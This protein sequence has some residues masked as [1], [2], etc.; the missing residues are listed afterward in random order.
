MTSL[1]SAIAEFHR[2]NEADNLSRKTL[3]WYRYILGAF[4]IAQEG[5]ALAEIT[6]SMVRSYVVGLRVKYPNENTVSDHIRGLHRFWKW[7][8][9][10]Y[11]LENP[12]TNIKYPK[13]AAPEP[14]AAT[15][16]DVKRMYAAAGEGEMGARNRAILMLLLDTGC[17]AAG[18]CT[19]K[20]SDIEMDEGRALVTEKFNKTRWV[21]FTEA[22]GQALR[23][24]FRYRQPV[25]W[26]FYDLD[27]LKP[28][29]SNGLYQLLR[30]LAR[31]GGVEGKF[32]PHSFR[33]LFAKHYVQS[34]GDLA[35]LSRLLGHRDVSTTVSHY[36][37]FTREELRQKHEK[38]SPVTMLPKIDSDEKKS[39]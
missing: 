14:K 4:A 7:S 18:L 23:Q 21:I 19:L 28:L 35:T 2:A 17:R 31:R 34:G 3:D 24:W 20:M 13:K 1:D 33:H 36:T 37:I 16:D 26:V 5:K 25:V 39:G 10:E 9:R 12:M 11:K 27:T 29:K 22:T 38:H 8:A 32:N 15:E 6:P 30:R